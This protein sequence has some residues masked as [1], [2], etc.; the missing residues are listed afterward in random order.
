MDFEI[1][2]L[3]ENKNASSSGV[4]RPEYL[5]KNDFSSIKSVL[6]QPSVQ[7]MV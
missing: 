3:R 2:R 7:N 4:L 6:L 1:Q 5:A